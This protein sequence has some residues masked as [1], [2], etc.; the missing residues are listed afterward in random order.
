MFTI[1]DK[2]V[3]SCDRNHKDNL[4]EGSDEKANIK[5]ATLQ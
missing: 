1:D 3:G 2:N 4:R 5:D